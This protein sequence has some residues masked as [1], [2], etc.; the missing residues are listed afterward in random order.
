MK[1]VFEVYAKEIRNDGR[2]FVAC[3][4]NIKGA[5]YKVKFNKQCE[6]VIKS[7]GVY[8]VS[9]D[10][11]NMSIQAGQR[12]TNSKGKEVVTN[13]IIWIRHCDIVKLTDEELSIRAAREVANIFEG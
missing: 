5:W 3:S 9:A 1:R 10:D 7:R 4:T 8:N 2:Q 12:V 6:N 13:P 11:M